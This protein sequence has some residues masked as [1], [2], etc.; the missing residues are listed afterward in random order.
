MKCLICLLVSLLVVGCI[1]LMAQEKNPYYAFEE[2][3][4]LSKVERTNVYNITTFIPRKFLLYID[5]IAGREFTH[6]IGG[7]E[8]LKVTTQDGVEV[9]VLESTVSDST[10][11]KSIGSHEIIFNSEHIMCRQK[12]CSKEIDDQVWHIQR[13]DAFKIVEDDGT[14]LRLLAHRDGNKIVGFLSKSERE[15]LTNKK[16]IV[17]RADKDH[18]KYA[19]TRTELG[20]LST[21][22]GIV[23]P[24]GTSKHLKHPETE[25]ELVELVLQAFG[26]A[27]VVDGTNVPDIVYNT[28][29]GEADKSIKFFVYDVENKWEYEK[30]RLVAAVT[31][32]CERQ[33][34]IYS[35]ERIEFVQIIRP[36]NG[37]RYNLDF[38]DYWSPDTLM[39]LIIP[40]YLFSV[41][42]Y[43][44]Y[45]NLMNK[46]GNVFGDRCLAGFFL[47]EFNRSCGSEH[48]TIERCQS[49]T[50][51]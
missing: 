21:R 28:D 29:L 15:E 47:S 37:R 3:F 20:Q 13:G 49:Y 19:I 33:G 34:I 44:Q 42:C 22:C 30:F 32:L 12:G 2:S 9:Y 7:S 25:K 24:A 27:S 11:R 16:G 51:K 45:T 5:T 48:R 1:Q 31:Y 17:T 6:N 8:F 10:F 38:R 41:N 43:D 26:F 39:K 50:Y 46:L 35:K 23:V 18:P 36:D 40:P 14:I 4:A